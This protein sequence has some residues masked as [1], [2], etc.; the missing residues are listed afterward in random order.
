M[1]LRADIHTKTIGNKLLFQN[2]EI[3]LN[4]HEKVAVIGRNGVGKTTLF[5]ILEGSDDEIDGLVERRR[6]LKMVATAQEHLAADSRSTLDYIY[7]NLPGYR[8]MLKIIETYPDTMGSNMAK[9]SAYTE[10]LQKFSDLGYYHLE[11]NLVRALGDYQL[12]KAMIDGPF[13]NLSGGQKRFVDL[14]RVQ[15]SG[16]D[17][18]LIDEPT[19]HMDYVAKDSFI[20]WL[21]AARHACLVITHDRDVLQGVERI[22][23][24]KDKKAISFKGNYSDYLR[25][26]TQSTTGQLQNYEI[27]LQTIVNLKKQIENARAK[28]PHWGGT[29]DKKNPFVVME[30]RLTKQL[31]TAIKNNP[32]PSFWIDKESAGALNPK[33]TASYDKYKEK[34]IKLHGTKDDERSS[35]LLNLHRVVLG[36][37]NKPLFKEVSLEL[38]HGE[39]VRLAGRNGA[40]KTTLVRAITDSANGISPPTLLAGEINCDRRLRLSVYEQEVDSGVLDLTLYDALEK[41]FADSGQD[42]NR[43][44]I[45]RFM[46]DYLF[47]PD[48]DS[49]ILVRNLSGGQKARL[50]LIKMLATK[51]NLL[52]LDEPTNH[53]DLPSIEELENA[54]K[55]YPGAVLY[56]SHDSYFSR[57]LGGQQITL[58]NVD[59]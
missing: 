35:K 49:Q 14:V 13:K 6:G 38:S 37:D 27:A 40:G 7:D 29:A 30:E 56:I 20:D 8:Q 54:L 2:L 44:Q 50:Q 57:N 31:N 26:N 51:P 12:S 34:N 11:N 58:A 52:I 41:A 25:Q 4:K 3:S 19:N 16:A 5:R 53:L 43:Q 18:A 45:M 48:A 32:K 46:G 1:I 39:R 21:A 9:I 15:F 59:V 23:E 42:Y 47:D 22:I 55:N 24:I 17:L 10:T 36:Y 33:M 28:K